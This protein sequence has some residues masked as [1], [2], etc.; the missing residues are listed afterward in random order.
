MYEQLANS[1]AHSIETIGTNPVGP[2]STRLING[3]T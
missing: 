3:L 2:P 1:H